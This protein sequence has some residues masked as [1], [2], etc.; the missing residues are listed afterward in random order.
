[1]GNTATI[2][3]QIASWQSYKFMKLGYGP[4]K[5]IK[6]RLGG[7]GGEGETETETEQER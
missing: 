5:E 7:G 2:I 3:R 1:M 4:C 6:G